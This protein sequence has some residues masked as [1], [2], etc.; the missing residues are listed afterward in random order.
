MARV[1]G[2]TVRPGDMVGVRGGWAEVKAIRADLDRLGKREVVLVLKG[3]RSMRVG[4][5][6][7][8]D[9]LRNPRGRR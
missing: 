3:A 9:V 2:L 7:Q 4:A 1:L 8:I 5:T 6:E